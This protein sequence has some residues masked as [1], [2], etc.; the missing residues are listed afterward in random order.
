MDERMQEYQDKVS[1]L[2]TAVS[3]VQIAA[4]NVLAAVKNR[5]LSAMYARVAELAQL[6]PELEGADFRLNNG[7]HL[8]LHGRRPAMDAF[9]V[10]S[11]VVWEGLCPWKESSRRGRF[12]IDM[13]RE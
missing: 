2:Q 11:F 1:A 8:N 4:R 5:D 13:A 9:R 6:M 7:N 12:V 10:V 3:D